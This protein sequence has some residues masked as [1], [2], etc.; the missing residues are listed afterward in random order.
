MYLP[1]TR[2]YK[3]AWQETIDAAETY[4][5]PGRFTAFIGYEWTS[6]DKGNN[7]YRN[8]IFRDNGDKASQVVPYT[9][10]PPMGSINPLDLYKWMEAYEKKTGGSVLA[11]AHNGN[12]S[13]GTMF[14][15]VETF[16]KAVDRDY[17]EQRAKWEPLYEVTQTK[18]TAKRTRSSRRMTSSPTSRHGTRAISTPVRRKPTA[19]SQ[20]IMPDRP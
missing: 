10:Y 9:C 6:L 17:A 18:G 3:G 7:L 14:P 19:C 12:L 5:E 16:G 1:G 8:V 13:N 15:T 2:P 11:L 4:N 20:V